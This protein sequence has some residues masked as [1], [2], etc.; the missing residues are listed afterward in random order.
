MP[1]KTQDE[2]RTVV[3]DVRNLSPADLGRLG[4]QQLAYVKPVMV[5][6]AHAF[7]IHAADGTPMAVAQDRSHA[8]AAIHQHEMVAAQVH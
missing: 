4:V 5:N 6:G 2:T 8:I 3:L 1:S 7:A